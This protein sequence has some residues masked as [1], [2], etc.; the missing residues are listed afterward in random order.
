MSLLFSVEVVIEP[1]SSISTYEFAY[2]ADCMSVTAGCVAPSVN[3][4]ELG[5][6]EVS[7]NSTNGYLSINVLFPN[8]TANATLRYTV[9]VGSLT[10]FAQ[11]ETSVVVYG[12]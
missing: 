11:Y 2:Q 5:N 10:I 3:E 6:V 9:F 7:K 1:A 8:I 4:N 12:E